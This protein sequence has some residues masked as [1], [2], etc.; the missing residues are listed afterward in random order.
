[1]IRDCAAV[2]PEVMEALQSQG[3][4]YPVVRS[5]ERPSMEGRRKLVYDRDG[6]TCR[7]CG[8]TSNLE[9]DHIVPWSAGGSDAS[10]NLRVLCHD[11]NQDRGNAAVLDQRRVRPVAVHCDGCAPVIFG[12]EPVLAFCG[13]CQD[14]TLVTD[15][16]WIL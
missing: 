15:P 14:L 7:L 1:M 10:M 8:D 16:H 3:Q 2:F 13:T 9:I 5:G 12:D 6:R 11:C 4:R